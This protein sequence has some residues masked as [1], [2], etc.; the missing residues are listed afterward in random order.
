MTRSKKKVV[1]RYTANCKE[2]NRH[3]LWP[4]RNL[5][6]PSN[7]QSMLNKQVNIIIKTPSIRLFIF[8]EHT[9]FSEFPV[10]NTLF[11]YVRLF[12]HQP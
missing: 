12:T 5:L 7:N 1:H 6:P 9:L 3:Y 10:L 11:V 2:F 8:N 4:S